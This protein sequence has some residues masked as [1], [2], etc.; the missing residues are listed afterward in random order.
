MSE[1]SATP[2]GVVRGGFDICVVLLLVIPVPVRLSSAAGLIVE[3]A[4][5]VCTPFIW[6]GSRIGYLDPGRFA[7]NLCHCFV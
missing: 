6:S 3:F 2:W 7:A 4:L 5:P 1:P